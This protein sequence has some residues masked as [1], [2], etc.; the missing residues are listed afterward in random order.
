M[1]VL[2]EPSVM[3]WTG[4]VGVPK[5][6]VN[7]LIEAVDWVRSATRTPKPNWLK[8]PPKL[9][10]QL[11]LQGVK[12]PLQPMPPK[13]KDEQEPPNPPKPKVRAP[14][15]CLEKLPSVF[16]GTSFHEIPRAFQ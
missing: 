3:A 9:L 13:G 11:K 5:A 14:E 12:P 16:A 4:V 8:P 1:M 2:L 10:P 6:E 15:D 7:W